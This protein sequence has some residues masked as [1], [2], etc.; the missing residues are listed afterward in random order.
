MNSSMKIEESREV[1]MVTM[2]G[3]F[4]PLKLRQKMEKKLK[5]TVKLI[6]PK[7]D[8]EDTEIEQ[9]YKYNEVINAIHWN[10]TEISTL[11]SGEILHREHFIQIPKAFFLF[12]RD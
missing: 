2:T 12:L 7:L 10:G 4:D 3:K 8:K 11:F 5:K 9:M 6:S 1:Y